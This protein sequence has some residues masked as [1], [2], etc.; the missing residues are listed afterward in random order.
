MV[1]NWVPVSIKQLF[2]GNSGT[3]RHE[4][5]VL[6]GKLRFFRLKTQVCGGELGTSRHKIQVF[7]GKLGTS[8][9]KTR[10]FGVNWLLVSI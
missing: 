10:V 7:W 1:V 2:G 3:S 5:R 9:Q 6:W 8:W 4:T